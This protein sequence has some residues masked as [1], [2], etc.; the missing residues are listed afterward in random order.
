MKIP[1]TAIA[2]LLISACSQQ[3]KQA[4]NIDTLALGQGLRGQVFLYGPELDTTN[5]KVI[6]ACDCCAGHYVFV[7]DSEV[8]QLDY[9]DA[10]VCYR[11]GKYQ[12]VGANVELQM[13]ADL[14]EHLY[15]ETGMDTAAINAPAFTTNLHH[16]AH[17]TLVL[18]RLNYKAGMVFKGSAESTFYVAPDT[19]SVDALLKE[20]VNWDP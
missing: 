12:I 9:C 13:E 1:L 10:S 18:E 15:N 8:V 11:K 3:P 17:K 19:V 4:A 5:G 14:V 7:N 2:L 16:A 20:W 6:A